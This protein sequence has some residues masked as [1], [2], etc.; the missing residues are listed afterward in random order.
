[1]KIIPSF[2]HGIIDYLMVVFFW[3]APTL[4]VLPSDVAGYAYGLGF[5]HLFLTFCTD[6]PSGIFRFISFK[7]H[8][9]IE[10]IVGA[11]LV[12]MAFTSFR[13]DDRSKPFL[14]TFGVILLLLFLVSDYRQISNA[15]R[16]R[17]ARLRGPRTVL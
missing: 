3:A 9:Y 15:S 8:S 7:V 6:Y 2:I 5:L 13:Y 12:V 1:M 16:V 10:L 17:S 14:L 11:A 4:F